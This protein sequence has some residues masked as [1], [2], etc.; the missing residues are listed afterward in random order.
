[1]SSV[2]DQLAT[3]QNR[4]D[5]VPNQELARD[6]AAKKDKKGI[7]EIAENLWN[8]DKSIQADCI[9]VLY[10]V[11]YIE[12]KLIA[13][14]VDDFVKCLKSKNN[15]LVW[16]G[17]TALAECAKANPD[18]VFNHFDAIKKAKESGSVIT[19]DHSISALAITA[20]A[21]AT[22]NKA[23]FP[24]LLKHLSTCRPKEVPQHAERSFPAV[25]RENKDEFIKVLEKRMEDLN[26]GGLARVKKVIKQANA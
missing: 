2:L 20:S 15:R 13:N 24:Y 23:I 14:Y 25:N 6:L 16:G 9:K 19:V 4:R 11:G 8:K 22:Y 1:M 5:E 21:N 7:Q 17:M 10:E 3:S 26:G 18:A 12:P